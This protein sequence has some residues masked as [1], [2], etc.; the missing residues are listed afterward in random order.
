MILLLKEMVYLAERPVRAR[1][2][3]MSESVSVREEDE[4]G[5]V[6]YALHEPLDGHLEFLP[7][8]VACLCDLFAD[9]HEDRRAALCETKT[10]EPIDLSKKTHTHTH[11]SS[12]NVPQRQWRSAP[13]RAGASPRYLAECARPLRV[14]G[15]VR[16]GGRQIREGGFRASRPTQRPAY[17]P[18]PAPRSA[19]HTHTR[20]ERERH[21]QI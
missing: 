21:Q 13:Q 19:P 6:G 9:G 18:A 14:L 7:Y 15:R 1:D 17:S 5:G 12:I 16:S 2:D 20:R 8:F 4:G 10:C 3:K 11:T